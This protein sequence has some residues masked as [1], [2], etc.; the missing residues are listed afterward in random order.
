MDRYLQNINPKSRVAKWA[1]SPIIV[2]RIALLGNYLLWVPAAVIA[3]LAG[4]PLFELTTPHGWTPVWAILLGAAAT[5]S[6][7][8]SI[9]DRWQKVEKWASAGLSALLLAYIG[10]MNLTA[11]LENDLNRKFV[12]VVALI[13]GILPIVRFVYLAAQTGKKRHVPSPDQ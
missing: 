6:A 3:F 12:G 4:V 2:L 10:G 1:W 7:V 11:Y 8:G 5:V 9:T 13:A